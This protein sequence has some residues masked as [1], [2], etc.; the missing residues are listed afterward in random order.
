MADVNRHFVSPDGWR[1]SGDDWSPEYRFRPA[2]LLSRPR[3]W[4]LT[5]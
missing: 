5:E 1:T 3:L 2:G 4:R